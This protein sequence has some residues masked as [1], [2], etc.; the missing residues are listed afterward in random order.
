M[1][2]RWFFQLQ[3]K[4]PQWQFHFKVMRAFCGEAQR[5][6]V[7]NATT[8]T[9]LLNWPVSRSVMT[10][11]RSVASASAWP[12]LTEPAE[13]IPCKCSR[14][15]P[16]PQSRRLSCSVRSC[17][18]WRSG[19]SP[20]N[21]YSLEQVCASCAKRRIER[22]PL[23][24]LPRPFEGGISRWDARRAGGLYRGMSARTPIAAVGQIGRPSC[25]SI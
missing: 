4:L 20:R 25:G 21:A 8:R 2:Q 5:S 13:V 6:A 12:N 11:S 17:P 9:G 24:R 14:S 18:T 1:Q 15:A 23:I 19:N 10:V 22:A 7:L 16:E 3:T